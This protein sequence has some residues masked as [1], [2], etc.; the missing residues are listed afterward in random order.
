MKYRHGIAWMVLGC[1]T[2][3]YAGAQTAPQPVNPIN[4][5]GGVVLLAPGTPIQVQIGRHWHPCAFDSADGE[6]LECS[7]NPAPGLFGRSFTYRREDV[8]RVRFEDPAASTL[9]GAVIGTGIGVGVGALRGG[10]MSGTTR[11]GEEFI[12]GGLGALIGGV[13]G[14]PRVHGRVIYERPTQNGAAGASS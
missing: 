14:H 7:S 12:G 13:I 10:G 5:W 11:G 4:D 8:K 3:V 9:A 6:W 2:F 1:A